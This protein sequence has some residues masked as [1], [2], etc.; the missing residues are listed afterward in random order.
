MYRKE[1]HLII[2]LKADSKRSALFGGFKRNS[3]S[4][5]VETPAFFKNAA[6]WIANRPS[7]TTS[8]TCTGGGCKPQ[9]LFLGTCGVLNV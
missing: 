5:E 6:L 7:S 4:T 8:S 1:Y 3:L 2:L 9:Y